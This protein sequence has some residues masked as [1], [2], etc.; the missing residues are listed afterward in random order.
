MPIV[1]IDRPWFIHCVMC[2]ALTLGAASAAS[3]QPERR[4]GL[5]IGYPAAAGVQWQI[6]D[7]FTIRGDAGFDWGMSEQVTSGLSI[8]LNGVPVSSSTTTTTFRHSTSIIG[9][10]GLVT[11]SRTEQL[12]LYLAP[13]IAWR[14]VRSSFDAVTQSTGSATRLTPEFESDRSSSSASNGV[15]LDAM[16][17]ANYRL[18]D[19]FAVF[20]EAGLAYIRPTTTSSSSDE[21]KSYSVGSRS[22]VGIVIY[23]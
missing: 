14:N 10:S 7:R 2:C 8:S 13:R 19:R 17:G 3:A 18:S 12:R 1:R 23:F 16:F 22:D 5:V 4:L 6:N 20:G 11:V 9:A 15:E 21:L